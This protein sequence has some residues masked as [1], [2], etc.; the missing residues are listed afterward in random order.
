V[1]ILDP[2]LKAMNDSMDAAATNAPE[3]NSAAPPQ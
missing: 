1:E 3:M 2:S